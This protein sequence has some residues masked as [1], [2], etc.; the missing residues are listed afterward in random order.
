MAS[1]ANT[2]GSAYD[3]VCV[4]GLGFILPGAESVASA[5]R[6]LAQGDPQISRLPPELSARSG[7]HGGGRISDFDYRR[8]LPDLPDNFA[9]RYSRDILMVLAAVENAR[10]D[11]GLDGPDG[12]GPDR[13]GIVASSARGPA[14]W[15]Y[16]IA[17]GE[18][19]GTDWP[20]VSPDR[21]ILASLAGTP[22]TLSAIRLGARGLVTTVSNACVGGHQ[23][24]ALAGDQ[25]RRG[26][27]DVMY[28]IGYD[29]PLVPPVFQVYAAPGSTVLSREPEVTRAVKPYDRRRDGFVL[30]EGA[31]V[32]VLENERHARARGAR[33][34]A[35]LRAAHSVN[36]AAHAT[37]MDLSGRATAAMI[38]ELLDAAGRDPGDL[39]Y[40]CGHGTAT[41]YNDAAE[42]RAL[43]HLYGE[44]R[45]QWPP[46]GSN[47]PIFGHLL[48]AAG[49]LNCAAVALML[50]RQCLAPT[51][52]CEEA[53]P[54]C[55]HDHVTEGPRPAVLDTA[56]SLAFAIGSQ[57]SA[58]LLERAA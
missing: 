35:A 19:L 11:A 12:A 45:S 39:D 10:R 50:R 24:V 13:T 23:A 44:E 3:D 1:T 48:G 34:Y 5:W 37:R 14:E 46:L 6:H 31:V 55:D 4:T 32:M 33:P 47:K 22:A 52:N 17:S 51:A 30:G 40:I 53:D 15:W 49:L 36:E 57:S 43:A 2:P 41:R 16:Q 26:A 21:A 54:E 42:S 38:G 20:P 58:V 25:I 56:M 28:V 29:L 7:I 27:A 8:H 9:K 18:D